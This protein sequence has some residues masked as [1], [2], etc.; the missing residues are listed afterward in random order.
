MRWCLGTGMALSPQSNVREETLTL[1]L[2]ILWLKGGKSPRYNHCTI[3]NWAR[4]LVQRLWGQRYWVASSGLPAPGCR[5]SSGEKSPTV[6]TLWRPH[7]SPS[8][9]QDTEGE[10]PRCGQRLFP[11]VQVWFCFSIAYLPQWLPTAL[12]IKPWFLHRTDI[13]FPTVWAPFLWP[14][15]ATPFH[16]SALLAFL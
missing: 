8:P 1:T 9:T 10:P 7:T 3:R 12:R 11:N 2:T 6:V 15:L 5:Q 13:A 4:S 16:Q 14:L